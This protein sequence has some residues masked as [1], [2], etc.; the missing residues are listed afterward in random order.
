VTDQ[1]ERI[2]AAP[3]T[4]LRKQ[5][6]DEGEPD[7]RELLR[8]H[9]DA[10]ELLVGE[11]RQAQQPVWLADV[12]REER[13]GVE[14]DDV[15]HDLARPEDER[16]VADPLPECEPVVA[17]RVDDLRPDQ[18]PADDEAE[19]HQVVHERVM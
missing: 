8:H 11:G 19:V 3:L 9:H 6:Q 12:G 15:R 16:R 10:R 7:R 4:A 17:G 18:E 14:Q 1:A 2:N 13:R 5:E